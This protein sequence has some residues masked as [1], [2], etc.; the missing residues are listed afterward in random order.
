VRLQHGAA[1][2]L[3][4]AAAFL[5]RLGFGLCSEFWFEDETQIFLLG[6]RYHSTHAWP[7]FGPDVVWTRSEIPGAL[8]ALLVGLP[9]DLLPA[10]EAPFVLL[11]LLSFAALCFLAG[12]LC[13]RLPELPR[14]LVWA[15]VLTTP[16]TLHYSTHVVNPS[17]VLPAAIVFFVGLW[18]AHPGLRA[19]LVPR[20]AAYFM[21]G[22]A[23]CW[24]MQVHMS[25]VL[26]PPFVAAVFWARRREGIRP[27]A[28]ALAATAAGAALTGALLVP[29]LVAY[30]LTGGAGGLHRN[31]RLHWVS[32]AALLTIAA[33]VLSFASM[34]VNRF[35]D[36]TRSRKL[37]FLWRH[38]WLVPPLAV[39]LVAGLVQPLGML[40]AAFRSSPRPEWKTVRLATAWTVALVY[41]SYGLS[42]EP[43]QAHAFYVVLPMA[44]LY[45]AYCWPLVDCP[46]ARAVAAGALTCGVLFH[47]GFALAKAPQRS[48]YRNRPAAAV[49]VAARQPLVLGHR[50]PYAADARD[51]PDPPALSAA[52]PTEDLR[53]V[54]SSWRRPI[55]QVAVWQ[56]TIR[57]GSSAVA[58]RD[59][60]YQT[61]YRAPT[62]EQVDAHGGLITE[63][64]QPGE[65]RTTAIVD[66]SPDGRAT[67][68]ELRLLG[69]EKLL[70]I[71]LAE[72]R[73]SQP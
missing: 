47:A 17:Y 67:T 30:G 6:L 34:E 31:L 35:V 42:F 20:A 32:P 9:M 39:V 50:R 71:A 53:L 18:E 51:D 14:W 4:L 24:T 59:L 68:A 1:W 65:T 52:Q 44:M 62:G 49:A 36:I 23:L 56:V 10:P 16:W 7:Y 72:G 40:W 37:F 2:G 22:C 55:A 25:W 3:A 58:Y 46:R 57:N 69:A 73:R 5:F 48:L 33:R 15:W 45:A 63:V 43:P 29:T 27:L 21:M 54:A 8:Q 66:G 26:L 19:G 13:A 64:L 60:V 41:A 61:L 38:P 12:Y 11:N 28:I 70:P